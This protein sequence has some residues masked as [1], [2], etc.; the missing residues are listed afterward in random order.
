[1]DGDTLV[2]GQP[3]PV[4]PLQGLKDSNELAGFARETTVYDQDGGKPLTN[5]V[6]TPWLRSTGSRA[7]KALPSKDGK[8]TASLPREPNRPEATALTQ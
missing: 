8:P 6:N 2:N 7:A 4:S 5:T 3:R 1:M